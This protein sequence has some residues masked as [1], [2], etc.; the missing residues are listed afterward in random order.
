[1][2]RIIISFAILSAV[3]SLCAVTLF[4]QSSEIDKLIVI[5]D[6]IKYAYDVNDTKG[7][8]ELTEK[9]NDSFESGTRLFPLFMRHSDISKIEET[10]SVLPIMLKSGDTQR[11]A[12]ELFKCRGMLT[13]LADM[14]TPV[15]ENIL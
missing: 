13:N 14:E 4:M 1:M 12:S 6:D 15:P 3:A 11:F 9:L 2:K 8:L 5:I 7:C 10:V